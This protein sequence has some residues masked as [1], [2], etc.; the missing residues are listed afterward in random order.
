MTELDVRISLQDTGLDGS[1]GIKDF[2]TSTITR[3]EELRSRFKTFILLLSFSYDFRT[4]Y[5]D[6]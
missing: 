2:M 1:R 5:S 6:V 4:N 3:R